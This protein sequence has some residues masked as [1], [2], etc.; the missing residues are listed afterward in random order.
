MEY[1]K[2]PIWA[3]DIEI[4]T[5]LEFHTKLDIMVAKHIN[6]NKNEDICMPGILKVDLGY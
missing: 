6:G 5:F 4:W 2:L 1:S 3:A